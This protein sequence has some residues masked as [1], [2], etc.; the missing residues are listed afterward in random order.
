MIENRELY[1]FEEKDEPVFLEDSGIDTEFDNNETGPP[2]FLYQLVVAILC[3][4]ITITICRQ[5]QGWAY[6]LRERLYYAIN[7][8]SESTFGILWDSTFFQKI[9]RNGNNFIRLEK[10]TQT[11]SGPGLLFGRDGLDL[12]DSVW[13]VPGNIIKEYSGSGTKGLFDSGVIMEGPERARVMAVATGTITRIRQNAGG[14]VVEIDH[15]MGWSSIYQ[16][17]TQ[18]HIEPDQ[19]V[20]TGQIIGQLGVGNDGKSKLFL[21]I[22]HNGEPVDPRNVIR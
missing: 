11:L 1:S 15:G 16:P 14:W 8:S 3:L 10:V 21:E 13:P 12:K 5:E 6:W 4:V 7:A 2:K 18:V 17:I 19:L 9:V 22:K 20:K